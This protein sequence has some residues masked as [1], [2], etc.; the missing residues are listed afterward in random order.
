LKSLALSVDCRLIEKRAK[1]ANPADIIELDA[2]NE[3]FV[4]FNDLG[5][6]LGYGVRWE[7]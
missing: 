2:V 5:T 7:D 6:G 1:Q 4:P 3:I